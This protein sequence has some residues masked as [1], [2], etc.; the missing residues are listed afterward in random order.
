MKN[1]FWKKVWEAFV[2]TVRLL[3]YFVVWAVIGVCLCA[4]YPV[5]LLWMIFFGNNNGRR[6]G[7]NPDNY[8]FHHM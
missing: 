8:S 4:F 1:H 6:G 3:F 5:I 7:G 2:I